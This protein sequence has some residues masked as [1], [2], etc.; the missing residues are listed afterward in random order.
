MSFNW[1]DMA[2]NLQDNAFNEKKGYTTEVDTRFWTLSRDENDDGGALIRFL[3]DSN[4]VPFVHL[5]QIAASTGKKQFYVT[6]WSPTSIGLPCP[7]NEKFTELWNAGSKDTAKTLG[8]K[9]RFITNIKVLKDPANPDNEGKVFLFEMSSTLMASIKSVM[10]Q[11]PQMK[12]LDEDPVAVYNPIDGNNFLIKVK[13]GENK[14]ITYADS[15]FSDKVN[16]IYKTEKEALAD[17][18]E[19]TFAL[20]EFLEPGNF[21]TYDELTNLMEKFLKIGKYAPQKEGEEAPKETPAPEKEAELVIDTGLSLGE[22]TPAPK[23]E[24]KEKAAPKKEAPAEDLDPELADLLGD[25][26]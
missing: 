12:S 3:P 18:G 11:T 21:K 22:D 20:K 25:L 14:I 7:F 8:R 10:I 4:G 2:G 26:D 6:E 1:E 16:G 19:S 17:I 5:E 13:M 9:D 24:K 23:A 15:K